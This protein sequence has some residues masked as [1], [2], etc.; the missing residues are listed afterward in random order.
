MNA[1]YPNDY[2]Y[3]DQIR[4]K[5]GHDRCKS[6]LNAML[7]KD[8]G[9]AVTLLNDRRLMFPCLYILREPILRHHVRRYLNT[10]NLIALRVIEQIRDSDVSE[11]DHLSSGQESVH[12]V[13]K[14]ILETGSAGG[15]PEDGYEEILDVAASVLINTYQDTAVLPLVADLMFKR[16]RDKGHIHDLVWVLFCVRDP[17]VL[18]LV[19]QRL[20]SSDAEDAELAAELLNIDKT[21]FPAADGEAERRYR[22][23]LRWLEENGPYLYFTGESF[24]YASKPVFCAMDMERKYLQ[25]GASSYDRQPI[26]SLDDDEKECMAA[27]QRLSAE[28]KKVLSEYSQKICGKSVS[29]WKEW[30]HTPVGEQIK[31]AKAGLEGDE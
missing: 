21:D 11:P 5:E 3:L 20:L 15:I 31:A 28:E 14:W 29:A 26:L 27:F 13:L 2:S 24:Q 17:Q 25:K 12:H 6:A 9:R 19:A 18:K 4:I 10:R 8:A 23:Y 7:G 1:G 16:N 30:R 22:D